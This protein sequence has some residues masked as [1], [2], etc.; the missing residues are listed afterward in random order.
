MRR[1][2]LWLETY[3]KSPLRRGNLPRGKAR[4]ADQR[5]SRAFHQFPLRR[6]TFLKDPDGV[7]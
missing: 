6:F 2:A 7:C 5:Q 4:T 1:N 3:G